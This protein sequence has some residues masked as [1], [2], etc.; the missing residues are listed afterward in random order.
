[1]SVIHPQ[2]DKMRL[3]T[4][5]NAVLVHSFTARS[6]FEAFQRNNDWHDYGPWLPPEDL[7]EHFF[8]E[9]EAAGQ[10]AYLRER[11]TG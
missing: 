2:N 5:P 1:M 6:D 8:T 11:N 3:M 9:E 10:R 4:D 7:R